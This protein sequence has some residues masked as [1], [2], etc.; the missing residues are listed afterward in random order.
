[1]AQDGAQ[2]ARLFEVAFVPLLIYL[3]VGA[4]GFGSSP[5]PDLSLYILG[6]F[7]GLVLFS[8]V[9]EWD[10]L[11]KGNAAASSSAA[12]EDSGPEIAF[13]MVAIALLAGTGI[14]T[15]LS[16]IGLFGTMMIAAGI[17]F[18]LRAR[19]LGKIRVAYRRMDEDPVVGCF[20]AVDH[21]QRDPERLCR[22]SL[23]V[24]FIS[25]G[26]EGARGRCASIRHSRAR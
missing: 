11:R 15:K 23:D 16:S 14:A 5:S 26:V 12:R 8:L 4:Y 17:L 19:A 18:I 25:C 20:C 2:T 24:D 9:V 3:T 22:L 21:S 1:M 6:M 10:P 13:R 7:A